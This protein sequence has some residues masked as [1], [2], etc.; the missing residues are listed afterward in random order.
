MIDRYGIPIYI[1]WADHEVIWLQA[2]MTLDHGERLEAYQDIASMSGRTF[3]AVKQKASDMRESD[4]RLRAKA[5]AEV[6]QNRTILVPARIHHRPSAILRN[7]TPG[8]G[9][10]HDQVEVFLPLYERNVF[11]VCRSGIWAAQSR[12]ALGARRRR[13]RENRA[14]LVDR[15]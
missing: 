10:G 6:L 12:P 3:K 9:I 11:G 8:K 13:D 4:R 14:M 2:A 15:R 1:G 7:P 5:D